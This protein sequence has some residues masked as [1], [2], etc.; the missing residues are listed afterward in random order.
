MKALP[1]QRSYYL[2]IANNQ[3]QRR[4]MIKART[5]LLCSPP[6]QTRAIAAA[7]GSCK[8]ASTDRL[9][10]GVLTGSS[11]THTSPFGSRKHPFLSLAASKPI[12]YRVDR[13]GHR[14]RVAC[15]Q[16]VAKTGEARWEDLLC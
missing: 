6:K 13:T 3:R 10:R 1:C 15:H 2:S 8:V 7:E 5:G 12:V 9:L 14:G 16:N 4:N 11:H